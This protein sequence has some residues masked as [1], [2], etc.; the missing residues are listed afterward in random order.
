MDR[1][2]ALAIALALPPLWLVFDGLTRMMHPLAGYASGLAAYW[3]V[4]VAILI[5][6]GGFLAAR[7]RVIVPPPLWA[8]PNYLMIAGVWVAAIGALMTHT[9]PFWVPGLVAL[10]ALCN[11]TLEELFWRGAVQRTDRLHAYLGTTT[12]FT[13]W[14]L[15][16]LGANDIALTGGPLAML[17]GAAFGGALWGMARR[18]TGTAGFG[19]VCHIALNAGA[20]TELAAR[21]L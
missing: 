19:A 16:L 15:A 5:W 8:W 10:V 14:H 4:L 20:F 12:L 11:G 6:R 2:A 21:N 3:L 13:L 1:A 17:A 7:L 18:L 9:V